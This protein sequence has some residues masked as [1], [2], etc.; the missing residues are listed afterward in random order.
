MKTTIPFLLLTMLALPTVAYEQEA[1]LVDAPKD[2]LLTAVSDCKEYAQED[3]V[4]KKELIEYLILCINDEL[5][6]AGFKPLAK[7]QLTKLI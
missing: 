2:V 3:I 5:E 7:K 1:L 4:D 6:V